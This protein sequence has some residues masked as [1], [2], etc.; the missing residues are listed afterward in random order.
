M[1]ACG[2]FASPVE[3]NTCICVLDTNHPHHVTPTSHRS[4]S[5]SPP[6]VANRCAV[7]PGCNKNDGRHVAIGSKVS[8]RALASPAEPTPGPPNRPNT[9]P[10]TPG[11]PHERANE[12]RM[13]HRRQ[14]ANRRLLPPSPSIV[15]SPL[16]PVPPIVQD[17]WAPDRI[18]NG[19]ASTATPVLLLPRGVRAACTRKPTS[20]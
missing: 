4:L 18:R 5:A 19:N 13:A 3:L 9:P 11:I 10:G 15:V 20:M 8:A 2:I 14:S 16:L 12:L 17:R 6:V 1:G 7:V